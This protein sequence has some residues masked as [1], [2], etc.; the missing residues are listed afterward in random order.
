MTAKRMSAALAFAAAAAIVAAAGLAAGL[1]AGAS[2][3]TSDIAPVVAPY[4]IDDAPSAG[5]GAFALIDN[6]ALRA[7]VTLNWLSLPDAAH[8]GIS[9]GGVAADEGSKAEAARGRY[10]L[11]TAEIVDVARTLEAGRIVCAK[12]AVALVG[13][14]IAIKTSSRPQWVWSTFEQVDNVPPAVAGEA[15]GPDAKDDGRPY[16]YFDPSRPAKLWPSFGSA[17]AEPVDWTNPP[18]LHPAPRRVRRWPD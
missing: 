17:A 9:Q 13:L 5:K 16:A 18:R 4:R 2:A 6:F 12:S 10:Y 15:R 3:E 8:R 11:E 1:V 14:H 7:F